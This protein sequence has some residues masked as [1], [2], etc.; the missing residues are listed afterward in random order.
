M[1]KVVSFHSSLKTVW[2]RMS[3]HM[4]ESASNG[5]EKLSQKCV[6]ENEGEKKEMMIE[7]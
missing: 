5:R 3:P 6:G 4:G 1:E 2:E 7:W